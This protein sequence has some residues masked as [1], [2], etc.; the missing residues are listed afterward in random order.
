MPINNFSG[1]TYVAFSDLNGFKEMMRSPER[2]A[3][4]LDKFYRTVYSLKAEPQ[5]SG[6]QT[7]A[8]SDCAISFIGNE[9]NRDSLPL[10]LGFLK[11]LHLE[12]IKADYLVTSSVA[13]GQFSYHER[14]ELSGLEKNMFLGDAYLKSYLNNGKCPEGSITII[15]DDNEKDNIL[16]SSGT[17]RDFL[18]ST[19]RGVIRG[20]QF[21]WAVSSALEIDK[22]E[23]A[24]QDTYRLKYRGMISIYKEYS[25]RRQGH[26]D[27]A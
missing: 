27:E 21:Y 24:Y 4:A 17:Y 11:E 25:G 22:F 26:P 15:C 6:V 12:M 13:H 5:Y 14:I 3:K 20:L 1:T 18:K 23:E 2:A 16:Q 10:L 7:L 8:V 19:R 9:Q